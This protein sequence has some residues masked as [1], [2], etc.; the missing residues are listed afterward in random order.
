MN[1]LSLNMKKSKLIL[2]ALIVLL[3]SACQKKNIKKEIPK[4]I[5]KYSAID[6]VGKE[7]TSKSLE[8][9]AQYKIVYINTDT[10]WEHYEFVKDSKKKLEALEKQM[11]AKYNEKASKA[12]AE[13]DAYVSGIQKG[14]ITNKE[15]AA[16]K[17]A[18]LSQQRDEIVALDNELSAKLMKDQETLN[19]RVKDT[20]QA[21]LHRFRIEK[22]YTMIIQYGYLSALLSGDEKLDVTVAAT[23][24][25][26]KEYQTFKAIIK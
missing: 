8:F 21:F 22:G 15:Q 25:L 12:Q 6:E 3:F 10:L 4:P 16:Q 18:S 24:G 26:N 5:S 1:L 23:K 11:R 17:E 13:Y 14:T 19:N 2:L 9:P 7:D 20:I